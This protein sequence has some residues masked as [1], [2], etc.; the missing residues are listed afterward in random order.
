MSADQMQREEEKEK[1]GL[2]EPVEVI[3]DQFQLPPPASIQDLRN[4]PPWA[5]KILEDKE[6]VGEEGR[7]K[8][9][10]K[11]NVGLCRMDFE[12]LARVA[13]Q[14]GVRILGINEEVL[15]N[16]TLETVVCLDTLEM[17]DGVIETTKNITAMKGETSGEEDSETKE[18]TSNDEGGTIVKKPFKAN[19]GFKRKEAREGDTLPRECRYLKSWIPRLWKKGLYLEGDLLDLTSSNLGVETDQRWVT[20]KIVERVSN[21]RVATK[22][23]TVYVLA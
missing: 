13:E 12:Q 2:R 23:G 15:E 10:K 17:H 9:T 3:V 18:P 8:V 22:K 16:D 4:S 14:N 1:E 7:T 11:C 5:S 19:L 20:S 6:E 21:N